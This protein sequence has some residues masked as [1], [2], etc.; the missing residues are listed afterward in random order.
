MLI[1]LSVLNYISRSAFFIRC[2]V[3]VMRLNIHYVYIHTP[4]VQIVSRS[5]FSRYITF[6]A[7]TSRY[8]LCYVPKDVYPEKLEQLK[9]WNWGS[10]FYY[11]FSKSRTTYNNLDGVLS[12]STSFY[13][14]ELGTF[15]IFLHYFSLL[16]KCHDSYK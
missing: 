11:V 10:S 1:T 7:C 3:F 12:K 16:N 14:F 4:S 9:I 6:S 5:R 13:K 8:K 2:V 15:C